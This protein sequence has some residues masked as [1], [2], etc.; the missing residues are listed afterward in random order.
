MGPK[1]GIYA[2]LAFQARHQG[3][4]FLHST[5]DYVSYSN[6]ILTL[7]FCLLDVLFS[8]LRVNH[9]E[10]FPSIKYPIRNY[11]HSFCKRSLSYNLSSMIT[12]L[13]SI[14]SCT[15][16]LDGIICEFIS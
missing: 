12:C 1:Q 13:T 5:T 3:F 8:P 16:L 2:I 9:H 10:G 6:I 7:K 15:R 11:F 4:L 14:D